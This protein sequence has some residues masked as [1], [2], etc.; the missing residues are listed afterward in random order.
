VRV[1][2]AAAFSATLVGAVALGSAWPQGADVNDGVLR[3]GWRLTGQVKETCRERTAEELSKLPVHMRA[4]R[5][6]ASEV[7]TYEL[8]ATVDDRVLVAKTVRSP[9]IRAD[10]PLSV[11][12]DLPIAP[13]EHV[14]S[15]TFAPRDRDSTG[16]RLTLERRLHFEPKRVVLVTYAQGALVVR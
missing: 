12:E 13:G 14:V 4:P 2:V 16:K 6:C 7:L 9:G 15:V 10:R 5:A 3:L 11:E 1:G 8:T